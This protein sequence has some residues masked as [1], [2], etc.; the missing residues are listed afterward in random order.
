MRS[1]L[2]ALL[3]V[4]SFGGI[5]GRTQEEEKVSVPMAM[6]DV[7]GGKGSSGTYSVMLLLFLVAVVAVALVRYSAI[8]MVLWPRSN[9][10]RQWTMDEN[11]EAAVILEGDSQSQQ[12][13]TL[14]S[15][16]DSSEP[17]LES[18]TNDDETSPD[19]T[20]RRSQRIRERNAAKKHL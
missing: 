2:H 7:V 17:E 10:I 12:P 4:S 13:P 9:K 15:K 3:D 18:E 19:T 1:A 20:L 5:Y 14:L 6:I 8:L 11:N 16:Q